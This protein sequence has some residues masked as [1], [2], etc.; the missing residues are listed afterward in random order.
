LSFEQFFNRIGDLY[1]GGHYSPS[2]SASLQ[3]PQ[4]KA[5]LDTAS[6]FGDGLTLPFT[7]CKKG[8]IPV[9]TTKK[10]T[11]DLSSYKRMYACPLHDNARRMRLQKDGG[12]TSF[13]KGEQDLTVFWKRYEYI[14]QKLDHESE[15]FMPLNDDTITNEVNDFIPIKLTSASMT[16]SAQESS[17]KSTTNDFEL[18]KEPC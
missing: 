3:T 9:S 2:G 5:I 6:K 18:S 1:G 11:N 15:R 12:M 7:P 17:Y 8:Y 13:R 10:S 4:G 16:K 14:N